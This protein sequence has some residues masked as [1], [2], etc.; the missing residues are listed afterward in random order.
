MK[1]WIF[2][3]I[4]L[5]PLAILWPV[6]N[7]PSPVARTLSEELQP[8]TE[9]WPGMRWISGLLHVIAFAACV[10]LLKRIDISGE[11]FARGGLI[12]ITYTACRA[13]LSFFVLGACIT[14]GALLLRIWSSDHRWRGP[15][16]DLQFGITCFFLG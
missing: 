7:W 9:L 4:A 12:P 15:G 3:L 6:R 8:V 10:F 13:T 11:N 14:L 16:G 5:L 1:G 2:L